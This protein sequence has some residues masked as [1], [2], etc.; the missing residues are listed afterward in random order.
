MKKLKKVIS[1]LKDDMKTFDKEKSD[2]KK[3]MRSLMMK[4]KKPVSKAKRRRDIISDEMHEF[5]EGKMHS[6]SKKGPVV[7]NPKQAIAISLSVAKR[8]AKPKRKS[9]AY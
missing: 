6:G 7:T 1:H 2:D 3:L 5:K 8:K 9:R 4:K